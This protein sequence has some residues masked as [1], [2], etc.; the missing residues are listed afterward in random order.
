MDSK[1]TNVVVSLGVILVIFAVIMFALGTQHPPRGRPLLRPRRSR[2]AGDRAGGPGAAQRRKG[3]NKPLEGIYVALTTPFKGD[4]VSAS[5]LKENVF[6]L[7]QT[8]VAGYL[9]LGSTGESVSLTDAESLELV[10]AVLEA[11]SPAKKV[12]VGTARES[13]KGTIDF[14]ASSARL[15]V[16][17]VEMS[18]FG[19]LARTARPRPQ[20]ARSLHVSRMTE[21]C[22]INSSKTVRVTM[23][24]SKAAPAAISRLITAA[25][26]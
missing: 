13:T 14:A 3:L 1:L 9:V 22:A 10:E 11:A 19:A 21:P 12:L 5:R 23:A 7:N 6:K 17:T 15:K 2:A 20:R 25:G 26:L 18:G 8:G 4:E 24:M 16:S